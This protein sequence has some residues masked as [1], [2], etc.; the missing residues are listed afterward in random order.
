MEFGVESLY[1]CEFLSDG[2]AQLCAVYHLRSQSDL[3]NYLANHAAHMR[4]DGIKRFGQKFSA[5]RRV[6]TVLFSQ[7]N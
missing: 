2:R 4:E 6:R 1:S 5:S 3:D 7:A